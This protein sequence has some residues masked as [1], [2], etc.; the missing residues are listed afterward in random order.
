MFFLQF[1]FKKF[2]RQSQLTLFL[3]S[4]KGYMFI[5]ETNILQEV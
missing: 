1:I 4:L 3:E 5:Y 2:N